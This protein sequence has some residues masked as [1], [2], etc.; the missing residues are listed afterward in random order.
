M[1]LLDLG[2]TRI[3]AAPN[4]PEGSTDRP[5]RARSTGCRAFGRGSRRVV[6]EPRCRI[7]LRAGRGTTE[8]G[9]ARG[10]RTGGEGEPVRG[11]PRGAR[12]WFAGKG[13]SGPP[14]VWALFPSGG[15]PPTPGPG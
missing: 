2:T 8:V 6:P 5:S 1:L 3:R 7:R 10:R 12:S 11:A 4:S 14:R 13:Y 9:P 15:H